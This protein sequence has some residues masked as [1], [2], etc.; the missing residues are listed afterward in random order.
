MK[1]D[2]NR[3]VLKDNGEILQTADLRL[4]SQKLIPK[5]CG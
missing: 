1:T 2:N 4:H 5:A 3:V